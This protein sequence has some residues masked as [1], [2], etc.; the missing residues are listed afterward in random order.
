M[1]HVLILALLML[2]SACD[3]RAEVVAES[4][5]NSDRC[6]RGGRQSSVMLAEDAS[7]WSELYAA[8]LR[9]GM[10]PLYARR[11]ADRGLCEYRSIR[12]GDE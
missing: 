8:A 11:A 7:V 3:V 5:G 1:R 6:D 12:E 2:A 4:D 9:G 10:E